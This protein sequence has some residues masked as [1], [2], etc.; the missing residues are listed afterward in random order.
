MKLEE[1]RYNQVVGRGNYPP[2]RT[3]ED[4]DNLVIDFIKC[5]KLKNIRD[6]YVDS[7]GCINLYT[8]T[9]TYTINEIRRNIFVYAKE[10]AYNNRTLKYLALVG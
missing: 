1:I 4:M 5:L 7:H 8:K 3:K 2:E 9:L 6:Y 10:D